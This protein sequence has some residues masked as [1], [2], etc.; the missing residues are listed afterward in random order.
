MVLGPR[1]IVAW[2]VFTF[3]EITFQKN[4][5]NPLVREKVSGEK[6]SISPLTES[7]PSC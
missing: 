6:I 4:G 1:E 3:T 5:Y 2:Q 7:F